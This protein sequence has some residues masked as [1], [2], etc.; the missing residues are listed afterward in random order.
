MLLLFLAAILCSS[1]VLLLDKGLFCPPSVSKTSDHIASVQKEFL[2]YTNVKNVAAACYTSGRNLREVR[3]FDPFLLQE[4]SE[5]GHFR[6]NFLMRVHLHTPWFQLKNKQVLCV[7][8]CYVCD[9]IEINLCV[10][11]GSQKAV[12]NSLSEAGHGWKVMLHEDMSYSQSTVKTG[13]EPVVCQWVKTCTR[14]VLA[15]HRRVF[16]LALL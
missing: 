15:K 6:G 14:L 9:Y 4:D 11:Q 10:F 12:M 7:C 1:Q 5:S 3:S 8:V 13:V 16:G 2:Y